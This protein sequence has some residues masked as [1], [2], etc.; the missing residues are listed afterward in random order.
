MTIAEI[1]DHNIVG[2]DGWGRVWVPTEEEF[3]E[4]ND[5]SDYDMDDDDS[6]DDGKGAISKRI[7]ER[8]K[9]QSIGYDATDLFRKRMEIQE[10]MDY[11]S[12]DGDSHGANGTLSENVDFD[13]G[14]GNSY[15]SQNNLDEDGFLIT[16]RQAGVDV[17]KEMKLI[18][19]DHDVS[20]PIDN[21]RIEL[22]SF[23]FSQNATFGD[24]VSG[25]M[26]AVLERTNI[27]K[28]ITSMKL[29]ASFKNELKHW[30]E[31]FRKLCHSIEEDKC[32]I[33]AVES[34]ACGGGIIGDVLTQE[35]N[36]RF[37]LQTLHDVDIISEEAILSWGSMRRDVD[38]ESAE[39]KIF[40]QKHT[41]E[42]LEW[43]NEDSSDDDDSD[44]DDDDDGS[45][46]ESE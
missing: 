6:K 29:V 4:F 14:F 36:F 45:G 8:I 10:E 13:G 27:V 44:D 28:D 16:G 33:S 5:D 26:L 3:E 21:L 42:F 12:D 37:I 23:K 39:G 1:T 24:C 41:Q 2:K 15:I 18:C 20:S 35:P 34:A 22:N 30:A 46:S 31:L 11:F 40:L 19:L 38:P 17:V 25:A 9:S 7:E 43:L 32:V